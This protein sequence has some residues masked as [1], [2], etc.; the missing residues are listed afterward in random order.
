MRPWRWSRDAAVYAAFCLS[1]SAGHAGADAMRCAACDVHNRAVAR[2]LRLA[3]TADAPERSGWPE[4][5][6][7][8]GIVTVASVPEWRSM[9]FTSLEPA[10]DRLVTG[11][12]PRGQ[13]AGLGVPLIAR[14][15]LDG[16]EAAA[17]KPFGP[18]TAMFAATAA[19]RPRGSLASWRG[20]PVE[21]A[22]LDPMRTET[23]GLGGR[24]LPMAANLTTPMAVRLSQASVRNY[25]YL[26]VID[27]E[28]YEERA[29]VY[30]V[31]PLPAR[32]G[33]GRPD[34]RALVEPQGLGADARRPPRRSVAALILPVLGGALSVRLFAADGGPGGPAIAARD[35]PALRPRWHRSGARSDD[36]PGQEHGRPDQP[37]CWSS[38]AARPSGTRSSPGRSTRSAPRRPSAPSWP[39]RC[40]SSPSRTSGARSS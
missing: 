23:L 33:A 16:A 19:I 13:R 37:V 29:G 10:A 18:E 24:A 36:H 4:R 32:Q 21:M 5:L 1:E 9:G 28:F 12:R 30:A 35:P 34:P 14:R 31:G 15:D 3:R 8:A 22:I 38:R 20:Q 17:W 27:P 25:E 2:C 40:S 11:L 7:A 39:R 26:G 6:A